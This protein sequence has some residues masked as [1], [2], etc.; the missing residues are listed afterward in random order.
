MLLLLVFFYAAVIF[1][2]LKC[3]R[4]ITEE[5]PDGYI[6]VSLNR[7]RIDELQLILRKS[8]FF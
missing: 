6:V 8:F 2:L 4:T 5:G 1:S 3:C 7:E